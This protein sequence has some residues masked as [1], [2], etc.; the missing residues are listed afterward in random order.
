MSVSSL[1][2]AF[3]FDGAAAL[4]LAMVGGSTT[5]VTHAGSIPV[6][7]SSVQSNR[8]STDA[9]KKD[10]PTEYPLVAWDRLLPV[11]PSIPRKGTLPDIPPPPR[12]PNF[13]DN[14]EISFNVS[15]AAQGI[16]GINPNQVAGSVSGSV[17]MGSGNPA[18]T[19]GDA[20]A[21]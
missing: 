2:A 8:L 12:D 20:V 18:M 3:L 17:V 4:N 15:E 11:T 16:P 5:S 13:E 9:K 1:A 21:R 10:I 7:L 19:A 6:V 14:P